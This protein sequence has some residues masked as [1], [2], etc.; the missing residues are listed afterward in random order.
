MKIFCN[1]SGEKTL[2]RSCSIICG[3]FTIAIPSDSEN[4]KEHYPDIY[5][6]FVKKYGN[7]K[8]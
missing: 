5:D 1:H 4:V 7:D 3:F 6:T 2:H 8:H